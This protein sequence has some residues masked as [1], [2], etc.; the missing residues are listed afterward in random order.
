MDERDFMDLL[1]EAIDLLNEDEDIKK[2]CST[3]ER[4]GILTNNKGLVVKTQDGSTFQITIV[5]S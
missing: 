4:E 5:K 2:D 1:M 3:F